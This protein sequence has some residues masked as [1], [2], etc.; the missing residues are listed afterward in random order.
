MF[1]CVAAL[2]VLGYVT[3]YFLMR[4]SE[5]H[6]SVGS[7]QHTSNLRKSHDFQFFDPDAEDRHAGQTAKQLQF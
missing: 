7:E 5:M 3:S 1:W 4:V 2:V 6:F